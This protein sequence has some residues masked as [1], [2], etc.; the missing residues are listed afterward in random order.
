MIWLRQRGQDYLLARWRTLYQ[1]QHGSSRCAALPHDVGKPVAFRQARDILSRRLSF[2]R[3]CTK[4][5]RSVRRNLTAH[6]AAE[7]ARGSTPDAEDPP[8]PTLDFRS[9]LC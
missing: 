3:E 7:R 8:R 2:W 5:R 1:T 4:N 9:K 6:Q